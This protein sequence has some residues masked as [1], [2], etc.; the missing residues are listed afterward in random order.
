MPDTEQDNYTRHW[1]SSKGVHIKPTPCSNDW[2][3]TEEYYKMFIE[4]HMD[5]KRLEIAYYE[6]TNKTKQEQKDN[7]IPNVMRVFLVTLLLMTLLIT[8]LVSILP[9]NTNVKTMPSVFV[10]PVRIR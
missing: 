9:Q 1:L 10:F 8:A 2:L 3:Y 7:T 5:G 4:A 6:A